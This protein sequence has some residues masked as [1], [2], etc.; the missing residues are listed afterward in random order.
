MT[1]WGVIRER[2]AAGGLNLWGVA[3]TEQ[4]SAVVVGNAG[5][6]LWEHFVAHLRANPE[7][8]ASEP[9]PLNRYVAELVSALPV[10][11]RRRW[12]LAT[13]RTVPLRQ[14]AR[15]AGLGF[16]S[17]LGLLLHPTFGPWLGLRAVCFTDEELP[18]TGPLPGPA[19]C[20]GCAAPCQTA[21]PGGALDSGAFDVRACATVHVQ[22]TCCAV[23][24]HARDACPVGAEHR[25]P[26]LA[27]HYHNDAVGGRA[28]L[29]RLLGVPGGEGVARDWASVLRG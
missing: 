2:L 10:H 13:D 26:E 28:A 7:R 17:R 1:E 8:L 4:G 12:A 21:C 27:V 18:P 5:G 14:L 19:P 20:E 22:D 16:P 3:K 25:Y 9:H 11:P 15:D 6:T 29:A 23:T 24:C